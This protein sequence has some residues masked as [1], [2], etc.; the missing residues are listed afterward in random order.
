MVIPLEALPGASPRTQNL[1]NAVVN[2]L[3]LT[4]PKY[5]LKRTHGNSAFRAVCHLSQKELLPGHFQRTLVLRERRGV[6]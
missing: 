5:S 2:P 6:R 3:L 4:C 1:A